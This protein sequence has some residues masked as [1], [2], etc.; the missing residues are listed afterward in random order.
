MPEASISELHSWGFYLLAS[1]VLVLVLAPQLT[2]LSKASRRAS[3]WRN[4]DGVRAVL[5][6][7]RP[8]V[9]TELSYGVPGVSDAIRL[10]GHSVSC[11]D[12]GSRI[13]FSVGW[14]LP[15][16]VLFPGVRYQFSLALGAVRVSQVV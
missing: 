11:D 2:D 6:S 9:R 8:G 12:G 1:L 7:L 14:R 13:S 4:L 15:D 16:I 5:E 3:D 10:S